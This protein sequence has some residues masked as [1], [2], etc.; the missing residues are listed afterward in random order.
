MPFHK[1]LCLWSVARN[2]RWLERNWVSET[3]ILQSS[4]KMGGSLFGRQLC[5][6]G[7]YS[8]WKVVGLLET[9]TQAEP[10]GFRFVLASAWRWRSRLGVG[11]FL[12]HPVNQ[13]LNWRTL[14]NHE[15]AR[16]LTGFQL[17][18]QWELNFGHRNL[19][20]LESQ[21]PFIK[22]QGL[23]MIWKRPRKLPGTS[24]YFSPSSQFRE[25]RHRDGQFQIL[26]EFIFL[27]TPR[28]SFGEVQNEFSREFFWRVLLELWDLPGYWIETFRWFAG[29]MLILV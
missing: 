10:Q 27:E 4:L 14:Q 9:P 3:H 24:H 13:S 5:S 25:S 19:D 15:G 18:L 28:G 20:L 29:V 12:F 21:G 17:I 2:E 23:E 6:F 11:W 26:L 7:G 16:P 8:I 1:V 22:N